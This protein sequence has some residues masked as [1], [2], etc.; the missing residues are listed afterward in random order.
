VYL[1]QIPL[2]ESEAA[3]VD[4]PT[5]REYVH[6]L[7]HRVDVHIHLNQPPQFARQF[8]IS[9]PDDASYTQ[10]QKT[11]AKHLT[12]EARANQGSAERSRGGANNASPA[13]ESPTLSKP[14]SIA[15]A[16]DSIGSA[17]GGTSDGAR[18]PGSTKTSPGTD[19]PLVDWKKIL[20][21][22]H[23][24]DNSAPY[25]QKPKKKSDPRLHQLLRPTQAGD[26]VTDILYFEIALY[27]VEELEDSNPLRFEYFTEKMKPMDVNYTILF[28]A[29]VDLLVGDVLNRCAETLGLPADHPELRLVDVW[30]GKFYNVYDD[31]T[32][33]ITEAFEQRSEYHI[34]YKPQPLPAVPA[35]DQGLIHVSHFHRQNGQ[36]AYHGD[37]FSI[38]ITKTDLIDDVMDRVA[39]KLDLPNQAISS[40]KPAILVNKSIIELNPNT[41]V[42]QQMLSIRRTRSAE[43]EVNFSFGLEHAAMVGGRRGTKKQERG[44]R[45]YH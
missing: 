24:P 41:P 42:L 22:Q 11:I 5:V 15:G 26:R 44:L 20:I 2:T 38:Y 29:N 13:P 10:V 14:P 25:F 28:P 30:K 8:T 37:P 7:T 34:E 43:A 18:S 33:K 3:N 27:T 6:Y 36:A 9:L 40:W 4:Y 45:I 35:S 21:A 16:M 19:S 39:L 32:K 12:A 17:P 1:W 31:P 23:N